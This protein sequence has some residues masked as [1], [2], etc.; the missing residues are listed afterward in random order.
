MADC[1]FPFLMF[2]GCLVLNGVSCL[3][4]PPNRSLPPLECW[5]GT[6]P[7]HAARLQLDL[8]AFENADI[9]P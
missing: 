5:C 7:N 3:V 6:S 8:N 1:A 2:F 9:G 4:M